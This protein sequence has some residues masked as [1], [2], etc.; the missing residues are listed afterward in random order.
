MEGQL[1]RIG[2]LDRYLKRRGHSWVYYRRVPT[3][4]AALD[5]R[6]PFIRHALGTRDL[7]I[8][9]RARD[10]LAAADDELWASLTL[11]ENVDRSRGRYAAAVKRVKAM[12]FGYTPAEELG[13]SAT[14]DELSSRMEAIFPPTTPP[15]VEQAVL[16]TVTP[17]KDR[18]ED[19]LRI[20]IEGP[21][22]LV[23][24]NKSPNQLRIW[25]NIPT[26]A[27]ARF[28]EVVGDKALVDIRREDAVKFYRFWLN[29]IMPDDDADPMHPSSGNRE[30]GELRK[31]YREYFSFEHNDKE[32][33]NPFFGLGFP[34]DGS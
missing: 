18:F 11:G 6:A 8:A 27:S 23:L 9:R 4:L 20:Y 19:A 10:L 1:A 5:R 7:A 13:R 12:G 33:L 29:R 34:E 17:P 32:R 26:R 30:I 28:V 2:D 21:G 31:L 22:K 3:S 15:E 14:W 25:R 16:G 24:A